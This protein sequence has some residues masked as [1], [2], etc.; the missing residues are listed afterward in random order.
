MTG[1]MLFSNHRPLRE[2]FNSPTATR[3][4]APLEFRGGIPVTYLIISIRPTIVS[5]T[6]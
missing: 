6:T 5:T 3:P 2:G 4:I 1:P